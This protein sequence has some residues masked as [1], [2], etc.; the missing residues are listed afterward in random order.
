M[1]KLY[2]SSTDK[3]LAGV[4]GGLAEYFEVDSTIVRLAV[5]LVAI[6]TAVVP[7]L[8]AYLVA[9]MIMPPKPE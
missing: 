1:K 5:V 9:W 3:K 7:A 6:L 2:L 8:L 4:C